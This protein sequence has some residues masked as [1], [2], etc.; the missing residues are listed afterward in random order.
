MLAPA[1]PADITYR[2]DRTSRGWILVLEN[3]HCS[4]TQLYPT[5]AA[6]QQAVGRSVFALETLTAQHLEMRHEPLA[7]PI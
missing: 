4:I 7:S 6:A 5:A 2:I 1:L 3:E